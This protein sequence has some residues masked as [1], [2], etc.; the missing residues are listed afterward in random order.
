MG[1]MVPLS[2]A[3]VGRVRQIAIGIEA[4]GKSPD[5][6]TVALEVARVLLAIEVIDQC[7]V[8]IV[9]EV[10]GIFVANLAR[11]GAHE[12]VLREKKRAAV[13]DADVKLDALVSVA[14]AVSIAVGRARPSGAILFGRRD[15]GWPI[16]HSRRRREWHAWARPWPADRR[17]WSH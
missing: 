6:G 2:L 11:V 13:A 9:V 10:V 3:G 17:S 5:A 15:S 8:A 12:R 7:D 1:A 4:R 16:R 14:V